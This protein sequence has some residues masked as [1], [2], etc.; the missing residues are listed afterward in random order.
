TLLGPAPRAA[1]EARHLAT[2]AIRAGRTES[3]LRLRR[4]ARSAQSVPE[5][6]RQAGRGAGRCAGRVVPPLRAIGIAPSRE[7]RYLVCMPKGSSKRGKREDEAQAAVRVM[8]TIAAK[9]EE[10]EIKIEITDEMRA[11]AAA[12]GRIG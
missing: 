6:H 12:F 8:E 7:R 5:Q 1:R 3:E 11:A 4:G 10:P 2:E 9:H